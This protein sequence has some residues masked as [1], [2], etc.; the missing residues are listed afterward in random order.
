MA[1]N[2]EFEDLCRDVAGSRLLKHTLYYLDDISGVL[3]RRS[4]KG[5]YR[6]PRVGIFGVASV[7]PLAPY[8][9]H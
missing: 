1:D 5:R 6:K 4:N 7:R 8:S 9:G 2:Q 3:Y